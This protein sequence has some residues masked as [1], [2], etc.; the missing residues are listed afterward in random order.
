MNAPPL[1]LRLCECLFLFC[2]T[3]SNSIRLYKIDPIL[4][5]VYSL[6][7]ISYLLSWLK[8][9]PARGPALGIIMYSSPLFVYNAFIFYTLLLSRISNVQSVSKTT[10]G[11]L[12]GD[13][14]TASSKPIFTVPPDAQSGASILPNIKDPEAVDAQFVCPGYSASNVVRTNSGLVATLKLAG[15]ACNVYGTDIE[16]LNLTVEYQAADRLAVKISPAVIDSSN[17]SQYIIPDNIVQRP[18]ADSDADA[19]SLTS[20]LEFVWSNEPTFSFSVLRV[21]T[22][23]KLFSTENSTL[24][25]ENQFVEFVSTLPENYNLYGLGETIHSLR[26]GNNYTKTIYAVD[27]GDVIDS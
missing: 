20:D 12:A 27:I 18:T 13:F 17:A 11:A 21:S 4:G 9:R 14:T 3:I 8:L 6:F 10:Y 1:I 22:G 16:T 24:I 15:I 25:F 5:L 23:D 7:I 26:L 19:S 2:S